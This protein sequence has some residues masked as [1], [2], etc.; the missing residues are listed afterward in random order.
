MTQ[1]QLFANSSLIEA[2]DE[3]LDLMEFMSHLLEIQ[4]INGLW[5]VDKEFDLY[6]CG[7]ERN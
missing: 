3:M 1:A 5:C 4:I 6:S 7:D 2:H